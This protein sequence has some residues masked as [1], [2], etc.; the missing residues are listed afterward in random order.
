[1]KKNKY[2]VLKDPY[3]RMYFIDPQNELF[4]PRG[5]RRDVDCYVTLSRTTEPEDDPDDPDYEDA[6]ADERTYTFPEH[7]EEIMLTVVR[8]KNV[9]WNA[10]MRKTSPIVRAT[11][12]DP[13][14]DGKSAS[15][16][17]VLSLYCAYRSISLK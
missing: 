3:E 13:Y 14:N 16:T 7:G 17:A 5:E 15:G 4:V 8:W 12:Y 11:V 1:M 2:I 9:K 6:D 10:Q